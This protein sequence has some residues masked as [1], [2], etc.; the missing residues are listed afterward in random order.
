M[1]ARD[2]PQMSAAEAE[3]ITEQIVG[4]LDQVSE[5][6]EAV[7]SLMRDALARRAHLALGYDSPTAYMRD[8]FEGALV[9]LSAAMRREIVHE[10]SDAGMS[11]RAI[12][13]IVGVSHT[14][15]RKDIDAA[16]GN[17]F[18]PDSAAPDFGNV[19]DMTDE[20]ADNLPDDS[21]N[22]DLATGEVIEP[23][24]TEHTITEKTKTITGLDGKTYTAPTT[25]KQKRRSIVEDAYTANR[26]L[27]R[28]IERIRDIRRDDR[29]T[30]N[31]ADIRAALQ[32]SVDLANEILADL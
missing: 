32:P 4:R 18:P 3:A 30:R 20:E 28:A 31:K 23:T 11:T 2:V 7:Q 10:L 27:F 13:P 12:A 1:S 26:E 24:V 22:I 15:V 25:P 17:K 29:Y 6:I 5:N 14:A 9:N 16:G 19:R 8:R 21:L